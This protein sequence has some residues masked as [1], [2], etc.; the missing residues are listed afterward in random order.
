M[1][2]PECYYCRACRRVVSEPAH[3]AIGCRNESRPADEWR[4]PPI[5]DTTRCAHCGGMFW[6]AD[7]ETLRASGYHVTEG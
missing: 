1:I 2:A 5:P 3:H 6:T 7:L 4:D